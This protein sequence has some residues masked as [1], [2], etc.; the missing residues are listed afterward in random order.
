MNDNQV[1]PIYLTCHKYRNEF[2]LLTTALPLHKC[3]NTSHRETITLL[4]YDLILNIYW[5]L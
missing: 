1:T 3:Y 5:L 2:T 4:L